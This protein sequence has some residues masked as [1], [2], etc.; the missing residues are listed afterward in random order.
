MKYK[1]KGIAEGKEVEIPTVREK[2]MEVMLKRQVEL[3]TT[4]ETYAAYQG[5]KAMAEELLKRID[6]KVS[7]GD[8]DMIVYSQFVDAIISENKDL[9]GNNKNFHKYK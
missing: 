6:E 7:I 3:K 2:D 5:M 9:F 1:F 4:D 8:L